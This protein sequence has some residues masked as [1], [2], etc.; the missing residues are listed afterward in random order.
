M[1]F[2][3]F[4]GLVFMD[5]L[6]WSFFMLFNHLLFIAL[7]KPFFWSSESRMQGFLH[8]AAAM[9]LQSVDQLSDEGEPQENSAGSGGVPKPKPKP[10]NTPK[11]KGAPKKKKVVE[12]PATTDKSSPKKRP[13]SEK[14][15]SKEPK[16]KRPASKLTEFKVGK[17]YYA[18]DRK[19]G[20]KWNGSEQYYATL[21]H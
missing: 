9:V 15:E 17:G 6:C 10:K 21:T 3:L 11:G 14:P 13:A 20:F 19:Y 7:Q 8:L 2:T 4:I 5:Q 16:L 12:E 1:F 18:R